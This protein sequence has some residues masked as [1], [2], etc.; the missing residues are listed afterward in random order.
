MAKIRG[1]EEYP[2]YYGA[3]P[4]MLGIAYD[5]RKRMTVAEKALWEKLRNRQ[6]KDYRFRRQHPIGEFVVD[7]FCYEGKLVIE[8][9]GEAHDDPF[10]KERDIQ[11][12]MILQS[13]G[14]KEMRFRNQ[15]VLDNP[16]DVV[17]KIAEMLL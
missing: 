17:S 1:R 7:F 5:L 6:V 14:L 8:L 9:D 16:D 11:R 4:E 2:I 15:E 12:T 3:N 10:Q 13:L